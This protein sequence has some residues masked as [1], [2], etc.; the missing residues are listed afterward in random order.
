VDS[1]GCVVVGSG[2]ALGLVGLR[3]LVVVDV[4]DAVLVVRRDRRQD[5]RSVVQALKA[6]GLGKFE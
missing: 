3:D 5:V 4:G 6:R 2:R 1:A